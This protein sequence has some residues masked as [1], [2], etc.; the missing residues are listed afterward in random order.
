MKM[1]QIVRGRVD[2]TN[3]FISSFYARISQKRKKLTAW[4]YFWDLRE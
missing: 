1:L 4:L 2:F 3:M